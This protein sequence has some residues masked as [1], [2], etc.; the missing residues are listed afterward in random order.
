[1]AFFGESLSSRFDTT[2][3]TP[4]PLARRLI[5][6]LFSPIRVNLIGKLLL[7]KF[8]GLQVQPQ[9]ANRIIMNPV[10]NPW[11][12]AAT[13]ILV[14]KVSNLKRLGSH[15]DSTTITSKIRGETADPDQVNLSSDLSD[16]ARVRLN[17]VVELI[18][19]TDYRIMM[20]KRS[21]LSSFMASA[22]VFPGR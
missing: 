18:N 22:Y 8:I 10:L 1:M 19:K 17:R 4:T 6:M 15:M 16:K 13:L 11:R 12:E 20:V 3:S 21:S 5:C 14:A 9:R 2:R 7:D